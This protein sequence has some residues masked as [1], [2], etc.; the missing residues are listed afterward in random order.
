MSSTEQITLRRLPFAADPGDGGYWTSCLA[1][2]QIRA[3]KGPQGTLT[4]KDVNPEIFQ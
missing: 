2:D 3:A 1:R 4:V